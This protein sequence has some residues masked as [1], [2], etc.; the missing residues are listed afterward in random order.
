MPLWPPC[1]PI[2]FDGCGARVL[3]HD[4]SE[5]LLRAADCVPIITDHRDVDYDLVARTADLIVDSRHVV[6]RQ[7]GNVVEA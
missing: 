6:P 7:G 3:Y 1:W 2:A 5:G 4:P